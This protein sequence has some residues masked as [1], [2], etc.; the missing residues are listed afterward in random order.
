MERQNTNSDTQKNNVKS[1]ITFKMKKT[2]HLDPDKITIDDEHIKQRKEEIKS[3][4]R[5][6][7]VTHEDLQVDYTMPDGS[8]N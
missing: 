3:M 7:T 1:V 8:Y 4:M 2:G 5:A 6:K